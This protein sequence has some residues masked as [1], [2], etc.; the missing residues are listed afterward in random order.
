M[1]IWQQAPFPADLNDAV[2]GLSYVFSHGEELGV[3]TGKVIIMGASAGGGLAARLAL[4][5]RDHNKLPVKSQVLIYPMLDCRTGTKEAPIPNP[6]GGQLVWSPELNQLGWTTLR[7][8]QN[9]PEDKMP[10]FSPSMENNLEGLPSTFMLV[11]NM[12]LF[13]IEDYTYAQRLVSEGIPTEFHQIYGVYH[14]FDVV[15]PQ[16]P[17]THLSHSLEYSAIRRMLEA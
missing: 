4:F 17:Q 10:Y 7:G 8:G 11:G 3:D 14:M 9:I 6:F 1:P 16:S 2:A 12:D 13:S 15:E 5:N